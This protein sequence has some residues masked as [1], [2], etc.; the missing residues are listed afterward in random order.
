MSESQA[1]GGTGERENLW[2]AESTGEAASQVVYRAS[3][4]HMKHAEVQ[5]LLDLCRH[6]G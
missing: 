5:F 2:S 1:A 4:A 3:V 6:I